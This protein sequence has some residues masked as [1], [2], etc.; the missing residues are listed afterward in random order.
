VSG[1][2]SAD[3]HPWKDLSLCWPCRRRGRRSTSRKGA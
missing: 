1:S 3:A 2:G